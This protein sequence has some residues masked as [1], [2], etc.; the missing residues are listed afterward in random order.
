M[1]AF[2]SISSGQKT[3]HRTLS[4][5]KLSRWSSRL[6][7]G[8]KIACGYGIALSVAV[9]G[10]I[11][12]MLLGD[13]YNHLAVE[14]Q[15]DALQ[16]IQLVNTLKI[17]ELT[18]RDKRQQ[19]ISLLGHPKL[20][21]QECSELK[22][23]ISEFRKVW[24][25]LQTLEGNLDTKHDSEEEIAKVQNFMQTYQ[26]I[27]EAYLQKVEELLNSVDLE[28]VQLEYVEN[29]QHQ[30]ISFNNSP[31][32]FQINNFSRDLT[33]LVDRAAD[34]YA[35]AAEVL[36]TSQKLRSQI[37]TTSL[38]LSVMIA[39]CLAFYTSRAI[40][41][42]IQNL[43][44]VV[45]HSIQ[46]SNFDVQVPVNAEDEV[47]VLANSFNQL[48]YSIKHLLAEQQQ[49]NQQLEAYSQNLEY[50][51]A[52]RTQELRENNLRLQ[53]TLEELHRTQSQMVQTEKMSALGQMVA[54]VAHEINNPVNFIYGNLS[55][56]KA[57]TQ[58]LVRLLQAYQEYYP[59][60]PQALQAKADEIELEFLNEDL[61]KIIQSMEIGATRIREIVKSLRN[62]SRLDEAEFKA[63]NIHE[64]ID[65]TL[66]ILQHRLKAKPESSQIKIIK[67]YAQ[68]PL[69]ECY[70]GQLNQVFMNLLTNAIDALEETYKI[71]EQNIIKQSK[72]IS[73]KTQLK[74]EDYVI[75]TIADNGMGIPEINK[76][77][78]FDPFFTTKPVG[79]GTGLGLSISYQ[80][81]HEKHQGK[82]WC[83][84]IPREGT[85]FFIEIPVRQHLKC[86][87][88][89]E[90]YN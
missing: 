32:V 67:E 6:K 28:N 7:V 90:R 26:G 79:K 76:S 24:S 51:V 14:A 47:G 66:M 70:A 5:S 62:F 25:D 9:L 27:P 50:Q 65:S 30:L 63:V 18:T 1:A 59:N 11:A 2:K 44:H 52:Q 46:E 40:A 74:S 4:Y 72:I 71:S 57:Y 41:R 29:I 23:T 16:E 77:K 34:E 64:G 82:L 15:E 39:A 43:T 38:V 33:Q 85:K 49:A 69:V 42:P 73:I 58:D 54:G 13:Y 86:T 37:I 21:Q 84:S 12:G 87:L 3:H 10:T 36:R 60:P 17:T 80:I 83:D 56:I 19:L 78:L 45:Q 68:L 53:Q 61:Q 20:V 55:H 75:I 8:Q 81:I 31:E 35:E 88:H 48:I 89:L 22:K